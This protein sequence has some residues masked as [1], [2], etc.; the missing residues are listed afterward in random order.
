LVSPSLLQA[1]N[2]PA[3]ANITNNFFIVLFLRFS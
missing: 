1:T 3:I 2:V